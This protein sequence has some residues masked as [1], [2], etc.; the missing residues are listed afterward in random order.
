MNEM[1]EVDDMDYGNAANNINPDDIESIEVLKGANAAALYGSD[2]A[3][4]VILII[5]YDSILNKF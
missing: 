4:G 1:G 5:R 3:N 2:G